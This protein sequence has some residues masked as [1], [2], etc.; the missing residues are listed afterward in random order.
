MKET[1]WKRLWYTQ[2][3][4]ITPKS[5][6]KSDLMVQIFFRIGEDKRKEKSGEDIKVNMPQ[7][8]KLLNFTT[9][10]FKQKAVKK[11]RST[12]DQNLS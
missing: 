11:S 5:N 4:S 9:N 8:A 7:Q 10:T 1:K 2:V 12:H 6:I 3:E